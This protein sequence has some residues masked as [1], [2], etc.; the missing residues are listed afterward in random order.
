LSTEDA[1]CA[2]AQR[3]DNSKLL[4]RQ[5]LRGV[6]LAGRKA[7][8]G[9][10]TTIPVHAE[11]LDV[12]AAVALVLLACNAIPTVDVRLDGALLTNFDVLNPGTNRQ[13]LNC[14]LVTCPSNGS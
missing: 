2:N 7:K 1:V 5:T 13:D 9:T 3:L 12:L 4:E 6:E 11:H 8:L 10:Q 14:K